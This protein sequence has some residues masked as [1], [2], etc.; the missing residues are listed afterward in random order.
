MQEAQSEQINGETSVEIPKKSDHNNED[1][2]HKLVGENTNGEQTEPK[3]IEDDG[4]EVNEEKE[5]DKSNEDNK[6]NEKD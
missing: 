6:N 3:K 2:D 5:R 4:A 1:E